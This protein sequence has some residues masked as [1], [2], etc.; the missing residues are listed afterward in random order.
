[1]SDATGPALRV[2]SFGDPQ[3]RVW[4][5]AFDAG[6]PTVLA[7]TGEGRPAAGPGTVSASDDGAWQLSTDWL[8]VSV[9]PPLASN[10]TSELCRA[11]GRLMLDGGEVE[12][13]GPATRSYAHELNRR[14]V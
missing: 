13:D 8:E 11:R 10:G 4:G 14:E 9:T 6:R 5:A 2:V 7:G 12:I 1:M 3:G